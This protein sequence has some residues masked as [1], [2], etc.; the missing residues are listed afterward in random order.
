MKKRYAFTL[1][2]LLVVIAII[3]ILA[4]ILF[5]VFAQAKE[6]AKRTSELSN[7]KQLVLG[8]I[9]Y[10]ADYDDVFTLH[11]HWL[12][13][14]QTGW[15]YR[16]APYVKNLNIFRSPLDSYGH[17]LNVD[18]WMGPSISVGANTL[19]GLTDPTTADNIMR[20]VIGFDMRTN[21]GGPIGTMSQTNIT[22]VAETIMLAPKY[23]SDVRAQ[24][25]WPSA[26]TPFSTLQSTFLWDFDPSCSG[27]AYY[28]TNPTSSGAIPN[29]ARAE[30]AYPRG[31]R[32][33]V[34]RSS[35]G[36]SSFAF[37][38]GH[39][40]SLRPEQTNPDGCR[41]PARNMWDSQR[42]Q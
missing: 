2:E 31:R 38:D 42:P 15:F 19:A 29:A 32:G 10:A 6:S 30:A 13:D 26:V 21:W 33:G 22:N 39:A 8:N 5:P 17:S 11:G 36:Q 23:S 41:Q 4:A 34:S 12:G 35:N 25:A 28:Y 27:K 3:A 24:N 1:I 20:G 37:A 16:T 7:T 14:P 40:K 9:M 18:G